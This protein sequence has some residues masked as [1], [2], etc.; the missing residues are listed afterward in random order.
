MKLTRSVSYAVGVLLQIQR[1]DSD[2]PVTAARI[3][4]GCK[5]PPR[6]LYRIL[7]RLVDAGLL[8]GTS[9]PGGGYALAKPPER[10]SLLRIAAGV[11]SAPEPTVLVPACAGQR[12][13]IDT[14]NRLCRESAEQFKAE[15]SRISLADLIAHAKKPKPP[16]RRAQPKARAGVA[17]ITPWRMTGAGPVCPRW[18][19]FSQSTK[20]N[21]D[22]FL[23]RGAHDSPNNK[24]AARPGALTAIR[25]RAS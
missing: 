14:V 4:R 7:R 11:E 21:R 9:G 6:F 20:R 18:S 3:A 12:G 23:F 25:P 8:R 5:F 16:R 15:L 22:G 10:I 1:F 13:A 17:Q 24:Q 2:G 19:R